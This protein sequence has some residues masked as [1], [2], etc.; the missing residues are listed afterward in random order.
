MIDPK[1]LSVV[2]D[3]IKDLM[4]KDPAAGEQIISAIADEYADV[5]EHVRS[6]WQDTG[7]AKQWDQCADKTNLLVGWLNNYCPASA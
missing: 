2:L 5:A 3:G 4:E 6:N 1:T 7:L